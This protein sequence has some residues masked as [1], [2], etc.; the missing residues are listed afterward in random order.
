MGSPSIIPPPPSS[1]SPPSSP[2][3][4]SISIESIF[5]T[6]QGILKLQQQHCTKHS[7]GTI[8]IQPSP[9]RLHMKWPHKKELTRVMLF[10]GA[11]FLRVTFFPH[12][13]LG[14]GMESM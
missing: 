4:P 8:A 13:P 14:L 11:T 2:P 6:L 5:L 3:S 10:H 9:Q 7:Q 12:R 1:S